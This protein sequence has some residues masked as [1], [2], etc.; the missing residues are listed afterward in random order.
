M[1]FSGIYFD[2]ESNDELR[3]SLKK[4]WL[5]PALRNKYIKLGLNRAKQF[6]WKYT[7]IQTLAVYRLALFNLHEK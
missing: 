7:A 3:L 5:S 6:S 1:D 2:P 4:L